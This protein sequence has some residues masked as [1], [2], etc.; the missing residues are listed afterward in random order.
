M[1]S[2]PSDEGSLHREREKRV[3]RTT[4]EERSGV[5]TSEGALNRLTRNIFGGQNTPLHFPKIDCHTHDEGVKNR[6]L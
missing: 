3:Y 5:Y 4:E 2:N 6:H 1:V